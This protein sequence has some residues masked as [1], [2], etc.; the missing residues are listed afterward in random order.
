MNPD[1]LVQVAMSR[2]PGGVSTNIRLKEGPGKV[3]LDRARGSRVWSVDDREIVDYVCGYG[4]ILLGYNFPPLTH[5]QV[6]VIE[7]G[8]GYNATNPFEI[9]AADRLL[10]LFPVYDM[11]RFSTTGS[12]ATTAAIGLALKVTG[13]SSIAVF[14]DHYHGWHGPTRAQR[15]T[16]PWS[17][18]SSSNRDCVF[19]LPFND[20][21]ACCDFFRMHGT[22]LACVI[23]EIVMGSGCYEPAREFINVLHEARDRNGFLLIADEVITGFRFGLRGA[24][25]K[26]KVLPD[27]SVFGKALGGGMPIGAVV[28]RKEHMSLFTSGQAVHAGTFNGHPLSVASACVVLDYLRTHEES[29]YPHIFE[30]A[31]LL[32]QGL[33]A[34]AKQARVECTVRAAGPVLWLGLP[35]DA[36]GSQDNYERFQDNLLARNVRVAQGGRWFVGFSHSSQDVDVAVAAAQF[37]FQKLAARDPS[38]REHHGTID[39]STSP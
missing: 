22:H 14:K 37:A 8:I 17:D 11:V 3:I 1:Q 39:H 16:F 18:P 13:R 38:R 27:M 15:T 23:L 28:G 32:G 24:Q 26:Y 6:E 33:L 20:T 10:N 5:C 29:V 34:A 35:D 36:P 30:M 21:Q 7:N 9:E 4:S 2:M 25:A 19:E 31:R 12:E